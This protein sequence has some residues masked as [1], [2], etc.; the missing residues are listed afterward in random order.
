MF[1]IHIQAYKHTHTYIHCIYEYTRI[2]VYMVYPASEA[3]RGQEYRYLCEHIT[4]II[5]VRLEL[6]ARA[7]FLLANSVVLHVSVAARVSLRKLRV[8]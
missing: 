2:Y 7:A 6:D 8:K 3:L 4:C 1:P 5:H